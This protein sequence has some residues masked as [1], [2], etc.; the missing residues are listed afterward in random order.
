MFLK[1]NWDF[2]ECRVKENTEIVLKFLQCKKL[3]ATFFILRWIGEKYLEFVRLISLEGHEIAPHGHAHIMV[4]KFTPKE[5]AGDLPK[6]FDILNSKSN[7]TVIGFR[8]PTFLITKK[9]FRHCR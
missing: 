4:K 6:L 2:I 8:A 1:E 3:K 7:E 9:H 5:F